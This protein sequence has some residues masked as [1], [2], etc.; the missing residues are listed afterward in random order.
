MI[1][2]ERIRELDESLSAFVTLGFEEDVDE[3][4]LVAAARALG[5]E[6]KDCP[7]LVGIAT[8]QMAYLLRLLGEEWDLDA[9]EA[10]QVVRA[11]QAGVA[12]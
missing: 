12:L 4:A 8:G 11:R 5:I 1:S 7:A 6:Q 3:K 9:A 2:D 10:W